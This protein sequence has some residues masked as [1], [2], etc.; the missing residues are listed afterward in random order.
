MRVETYFGAVTRAIPFRK[1]L[2]E[3]KSSVTFPP[4][5]GA[6]AEI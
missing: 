1:K 4:R 3:Q 6:E 5:N 2:L